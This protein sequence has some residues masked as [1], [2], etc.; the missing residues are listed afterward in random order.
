[1]VDVVNQEYGKLLGKKR[2]K[3]NW[4]LASSEEEVI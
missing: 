4:S 2:K 3:I 1:V